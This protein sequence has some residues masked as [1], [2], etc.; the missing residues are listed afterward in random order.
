MSFRRCTSGEWSAR[1]HR[2]YA[3]HVH[4]QQHDGQSA[5]GRPAAVQCREGLRPHQPIH[6]TPPGCCTSMPSY[7][8]APWRRASP[9]PRRR[10]G[11]LPLPARVWVGCRRWQQTGSSSWP[12]SAS[13]TSL[14]VAPP[15][16]RPWQADL[17]TGT[18]DATFFPLVGVVEQVRSG[19]LRALAVAS[20]GRG[21]RRP[22]DDAARGAHFR[23]SR[24][25]RIQRPGMG[26]PAGSGGHAGACDRAAG[27]GQRAR[28]GG[29]RSASS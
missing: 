13:I 17:V 19:R 1:A 10:R 4:A 5:A 18:V 21:Q 8:H 11:G 7:R 20:T 23:R 27:P 2:L 14:M 24:L 12:A 9:W 3:G 16:G 26:R 22:V 29:P 25:P 15:T 28:R 6:R